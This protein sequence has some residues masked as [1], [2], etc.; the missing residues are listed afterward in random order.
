MSVAALDLRSVICIPLVRIRTQNSIDTIVADPNDTLGLIYL[1][2]KIEIADLSAGNREILQTLAL[3]AS[4]ILENARLLEQDRVRQ[5][6]EEE[7]RIARQIQQSLFPER[8]PSEGWFRASG[9]SIPSQQVGGDVYDV[10]RIDENHWHFLVADVSGKGVSSA[11][12]AALLQGGFVLVP[13]DPADVARTLAQLNRYIYE[14]AA[15]EKYATLFYAALRRDGRLYW[16]NAGHCEPIV[17]HEGGV[18]EVLKST[19]LPLGMLDEVEFEVCSTHLRPCDR[20]VIYSDGLSDARDGAGA[21][22]G[23]ERIRAVVEALPNGSAAQLHAA[24]L[25]AVTQ[26]SGSAPQPDDITVLVTEYRPGPV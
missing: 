19:S 6:M 15:G 3:E 24:L 1:D 7:L 18:T 2:S 13:S 12:L 9:A 25:T 14:R 5:R 26:F 16:C 21:T 4:T 17:L 10:A 23:A 22:F 20:I 8:L 11:L